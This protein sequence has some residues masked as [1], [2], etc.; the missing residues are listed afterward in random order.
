MSEKVEYATLKKYRFAHTLFL[1]YQIKIAFSL[2]KNTD[3]NI[4]FCKNLDEAKN[5]L[6]DWGFIPVSETFYYR[7][8]QD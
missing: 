5:I 3:R 4:I 6:C 2:P 8:D 1:S 7:K